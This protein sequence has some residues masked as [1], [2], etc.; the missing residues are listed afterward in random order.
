MNF[1][2]LP[3]EIT[4]LLSSINAPERL[5]RHLRIVNHTA[6]E[7]IEALKNK[8]PGITFKEQEVLF[9]AATH[10]IG[11]AAVT[12]EL[13]EDGKKHE[14]EG[15]RLLIKHGFPDNLA[16][17]A[18]THGTWPDDGLP[19]EDLLVCLADTVWTGQRLDALEEKVIQRLAERLHVDYWEVF[20]VM[21]E[22]ISHVSNDAD[23]KMAWQ[24][25]GG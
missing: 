21:D 8:W 15:Y 25:M 7:L 13:Y 19:L 24:G 16:R 6:Y 9:G 5:K 10:D 22:I 2:A 11:K 23:Q 18:K 3:S 12:S 14:D 1:I 4:N 20:P 17:F